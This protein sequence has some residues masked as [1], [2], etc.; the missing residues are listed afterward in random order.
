[1]KSPA[2]L[3]IALMA[4]E[5]ASSSM[6]DGG[7]LMAAETSAP[8]DTIGIYDSRAVAYAH[9]WSDGHQRKLNDLSKAAK[10]A[11]S[12]GQDERFKELEEA[13][14]KEQEKSHLQVFSTAPVDDVLAG[15]KD[16]L[17]VIE[18]E[19]GV[20]TLVSKWDEPALQKHR[21]AKQV[22]VTDLL[23]R[24]FK[25]DEKKMKAVQDIGKQKPLPLDQAQELTRKGKL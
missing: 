24:E 1:M 21:G 13:L 11:K 25:L 19:A 23:L 16:R 20:A 7:L 5:A 3:S 2:I 14:K 8:P 17:T 22:D 6:T 18:Q 12:G 15:M 9:F 10:A 4:G